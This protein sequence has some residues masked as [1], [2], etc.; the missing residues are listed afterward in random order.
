MIRRRAVA[1]CAV[2]PAPTWRAWVVAGLLVSAGP[3]AA[4]APVVA[5]YMLS[6]Q[7]CHLPDGSGFPA[8]GVPAF[9]GFVGRFL[10]V[11]GGREFLIRVPGVAQSGLPDDRLATLMNWLLKTYSAAELPPDFHPYT[12]SEI[13]QWRRLPLVDVRATRAQLVQR[14]ARLPS[15]SSNR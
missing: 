3:A 5:D 15:A 7:G 9:P 13:A 6:C 4:T 8:H 11:D 12:A 2:L 10:H 14:M 1:F